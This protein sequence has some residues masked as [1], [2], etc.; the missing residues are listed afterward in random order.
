MHAIAGC[1][2]STNEKVWVLKIP[3]EQ[4]ES[5]VNWEE[6]K[7]GCFAHLYGADLGSMEI[8]NMTAFTRGDG[9]DWTATLEKHEWLL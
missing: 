9:E 1:F 6:A 4:I 7:S 8:E 5:N 3:L 2:F